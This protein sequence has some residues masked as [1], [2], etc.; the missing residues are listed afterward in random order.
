MVELR[1]DFAMLRAELGDIHAKITMMQGDIAGLRGTG[2]FRDGGDDE[3]I[4]DFLG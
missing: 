3:G 4:G 2:G 1:D